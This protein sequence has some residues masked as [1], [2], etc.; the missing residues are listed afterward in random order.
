MGAAF[1]FADGDA[2][3]PRWGVDE[4]LIEQVDN[5]ENRKREEVKA[6][7][8]IG[9]A[10]E[11]RHDHALQTHVR[12]CVRAQFAGHDDDVEHGGDSQRDQR[13]GDPLHAR[14]H[15]SK[16]NGLQDR[17][18]KDQ[19]QRGKQGQAETLDGN[20]GQV[21]AHGEEHRMTEGKQTRDAEDQV[22]TQGVEGKD[23]DLDGKSLRELGIAGLVAPHRERR[24]AVQQT[25]EE[26]Q[27]DESDES[28]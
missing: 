20:A 8:F 1:V 22:V 5:D 2:H 18:E 27:E 3:A 9:G 16:Q 19:S 13:K 26:G 17:G 21:R 15:K 14:K 6:Q 25:D 11:G 24:R 7:A 10:D 12:A 4:A 23:E 28:D